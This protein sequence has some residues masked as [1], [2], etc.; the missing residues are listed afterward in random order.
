MRIIPTSL[1]L[2]LILF[3]SISGFAAAQ[4]MPQTADENAWR[5]RCDDS[6]LDDTSRQC[7]MFQRLSL[8]ETGQRVM[9]FAVGYPPEKDQ[10]RGVLVLPVGVLLNEAMTIQIDQ[11]PSFSFKVRY[12][13]QD[14]CYAFLTLSDSVVSMMKN[15]KLMR[16]GF[17]ALDEEAVSLD[18]VLT[19]F[20]EGLERISN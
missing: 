17:T 18:L 7:E 11:N 6:A 19:G 9:E 1:F 13:L 12:C 15:G 20:N 4:D 10:A 3:I 5:I 14:G 8:M 16:V 2:T